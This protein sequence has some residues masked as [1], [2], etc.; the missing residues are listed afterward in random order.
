VLAS[1]Q[2]SI[3]KIVKNNF[4]GI[5]FEKGN[6]IEL[7]NKIEWMIKN[8][9]KVNAMALNAKKDFDQNFSPENSFSLIKKIYSKAII[10]K[11]T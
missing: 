10:D 11:K 6:H 2:P 1:D 9:E 8:E 3:K 7:K 5:L 4:N